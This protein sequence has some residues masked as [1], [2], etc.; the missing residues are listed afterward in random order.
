MG[1]DGG[2]MGEEWMGFGC[3]KMRLHRQP[4]PK[5]LA[6]VASVP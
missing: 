3:G 6:F 2:W 4:S 1:E 5:N